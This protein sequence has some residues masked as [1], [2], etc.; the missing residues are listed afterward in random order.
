MRYDSK[1]EYHS[2]LI[3][4][5]IQANEGIHLS[6]KSVHDI[7]SNVDT[8]A[9]YWKDTVDNMME[10]NYPLRWNELRIYLLRKQ[11]K[12]YEHVLEMMA[13]LDRKESLR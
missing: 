8:V 9:E 10:D 5:H 4:Y 13:K 12:G 6:E 3:T 2:H 1:S 7:Y 11:P